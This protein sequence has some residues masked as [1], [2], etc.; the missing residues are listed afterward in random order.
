VWK[1]FWALIR[2]FIASGAV[3]ADPPRFP[4]S[5]HHSIY[6]HKVQADIQRYVMKAFDVALTYDAIIPTSVIRLRMVDALYSNDYGH[7]PLDNFERRQAEEKYLPRIIGWEKQIS[8]DRYFVI[9]VPNLQFDEYDVTNSE[10]HFSLPLVQ[11]MSRFR[12]LAQEPGVGI[13]PN[14]FRVANNSMKISRPQAEKFSSLLNG[15]IF[16][17][18]AV[19]IYR[20]DR[21]WITT[22]AEY[23]IIADIEVLMVFG[24]DYRTYHIFY[25]R[26]L[27]K[28]HSLE[29]A[30]KAV[31]DSYT[32]GMRLPEFGVISDAAVP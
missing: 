31:T 14:V 9:R 19:G 25:A 17:G 28:S 6:L 23:C 7:V 15:R 5:R 12:M 24:P 8:S 21:T 11:P 18:D 4:F 22:T 10:Y 13:C 1:A 26:N 32:Q 27:V 16:T 2:C 29:E 30:I 3:L 20:T